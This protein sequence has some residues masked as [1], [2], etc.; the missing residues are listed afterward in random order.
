M[1]RLFQG[2]S[3]EL[4]PFPGWR[5]I[6]H[7]P[8]V[9][10]PRRLVCAALLAALA[11]LV[12]TGCEIAEPELPSY[13]THLAIPLGQ[14]RLDIADVVEDE[15]YLVSLADGALGFHVD[16]DPD[17]VSLDFDLAADISPQTISGDLGN[18]A[19]EIASPP[20]FA[21]ALRDLYPDADAV[22]G[23]TVPVP[24][25]QFATASDAQDL[26]DLE[27][28]TLAGG[29][30]TVTVTN[31]LPVPVSAPA[32]DPDRLVLE[33]VDLEADTAVVVGFEFD[34]I[35]AGATASETADL[36][37]VTL[38]GALAVR[39]DGGSP[40]SGGAPVLIDADA[41]IGVEAAF[42]DLTVA[43]AEA[44][45]DAQEFSTGF[46]T[47]LPADYEVVQAVIGGGSVTLT[48]ANEM[49]IPCQ[50][51]VSWPEIVDL[52]G[53]PL[54]LVL[55]LPPHADDARS[56][57]FAGHVVQASP[58]EQLT[59]L[60]ATVSVTSPGSGG[61]P[62][63][64]TADDGVTADLTGGRIEFGSVTGVV[65]EL[66]YDFADLREEI[67][68]PDEIEGL[69][70]TAATMVLELENTAGI[71]AET[72]FELVG[73]NEDGVPHT[74]TVQEQIAA[75]E[76]E[77]AAVTRI[78]LDQTNSSIVDLLN[79]MP[80]EIALTG[81][82][83]L[84]GGGQVGTVRAGDRAVVRWDI[85]APVEVVIESSR[86]Y[87]DP[88]ALD[89]DADARDRIADHAGAAGLQLEVLNHLPVGIE[90]RVLFAPDTTTIKTDPLL[91]VGPVTVDAAAVDPVTH[92]VSEPRVSRPVLALD[93][94][95]VQVLA[96]EG[97]YQVI[98]VRLPSTDGQPVRVLT[99]DY[100]E[101]N[102]LIDLDVRVHDDG[103]DD[104]AAN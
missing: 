28:A 54:S 33:L 61:Q 70:L 34:P 92:V 46:A 6:M 76:G 87:G 37:G 73:V 22:D 27:S 74:L 101:I 45:V 48:V 20:S 60:S 10:L 64:L 19:L 93:A 100:V 58:G 26:A 62:V 4:T 89:L 5:T 38:P 1:V 32:G 66:T 98:E 77:R 69:S 65:P 85:T 12:L 59:Q 55:D 95:E 21:F 103:D 72:R 17:T 42:A 68:L 25:F 79:H 9:N 102:G 97:L 3:R 35:A 30:I 7:C 11:G 99:T 71:A 51:V 15:D 31:G 57:D 81:G 82:V 75:A 29:T 40:G 47:E 84:G 43:S 53:V 36:A 91:A 90:A 94:D 104:D 88:E 23:F 41:A 56:V 96:T 67:D 80:T 44:A 13:Q 63:L 18:F 2:A 49:A 86:L 14:D 83:A 16:G 52:D 50:A 8:R 24:S 78:T 39:L